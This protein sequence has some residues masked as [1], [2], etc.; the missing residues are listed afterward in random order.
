M[1]IVNLFK[2]GVEEV[3]IRSSKPIDA[4]ELIQKEFD[5]YDYC[6]YDYAGIFFDYSDDTSEF[7][8]G[9][10]FPVIIDEIYPL[11]TFC[12]VYQVDS[13]TVRFENLFEND[14]EICVICNEEFKGQGNNPEPIKDEGQ[15]CDSCN[16]NYVIPKRMEGLL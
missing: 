11:G 4:Y 5:E 1:D 3:V 9:E 16:F 10:L 13:Y 14:V 6:Y 2:N 8:V 7:E 15:C 12:N